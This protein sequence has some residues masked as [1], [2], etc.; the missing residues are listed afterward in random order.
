MSRGTRKEKERERR[1]EE[2]R[3]RKVWSGKMRRHSKGAQG[4][5]KTRTKGIKVF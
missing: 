5:G 3:E 2:N 4:S 1:V